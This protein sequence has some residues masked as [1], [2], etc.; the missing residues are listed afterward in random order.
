MNIQNVGGVTP[1]TSQPLV[2]PGL[3]NCIPTT[4]R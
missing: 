2:F 3:E 1:A 4:T